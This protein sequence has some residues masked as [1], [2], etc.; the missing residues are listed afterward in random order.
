MVNEP[1]GQQ[2][3]GRRVLWSGSRCA[4]RVNSGHNGAREPSATR[5]YCKARQT[6]NPS[7]SHR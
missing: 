2:T 1:L 7:Q 4:P 3:Q 6:H 5:R